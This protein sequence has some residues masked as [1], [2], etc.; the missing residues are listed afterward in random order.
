M[1]AY[2]RTYWSAAPFAPVG[3]TELQESVL[4]NAAGKVVV[5]AAILPFLHYDV[6][7]SLVGVVGRGV[8]KEGFLPP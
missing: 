6:L 2:S 5:S 7:H 8:D 1:R 3:G 4:G